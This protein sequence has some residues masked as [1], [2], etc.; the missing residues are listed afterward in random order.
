MS[1]SDPQFLYII[2]VLPGLFG[3]TLIGDGLSK[4]IHEEWIGVL[5]ILIGLACFAGVAVA[6]FYFSSY[7]GSKI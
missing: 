5:I 2:L 3:L 1:A 4:V 7:L 6:Y